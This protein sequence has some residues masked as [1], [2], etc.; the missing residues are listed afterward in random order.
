MAEGARPIRGRTGK[1]HPF[2]AELYLGDEPDE[3][4]Q[5][6]GRSRRRKAVVQR[7]GAS[8]QRDSQ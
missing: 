3:E 7:R 4:S 6:E 2:F 8:G 5:T 1:V